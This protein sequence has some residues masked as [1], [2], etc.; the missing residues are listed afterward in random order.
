MRLQTVAKHRKFANRQAEQLGILSG[1]FQ[2]NNRYGGG[3]L[4]LIRLAL[5]GGLPCAAY[6]NFVR[7]PLR[8]I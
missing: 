6:P 5:L 2:E 8:L 3:F 1:Q 7:I 4:Q